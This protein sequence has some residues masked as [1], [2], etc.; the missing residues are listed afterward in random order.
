M[1]IYQWLNWGLGVSDH[2]A[3]DSRPS[4]SGGLRVWRVSF[5]EVVGV[6]MENDASAHH[7]NR[8]SQRSHRVR[9]VDVNVSG[10]ISLDVSE[11]ANM[12]VSVSW[13]SV[14]LSRWIIVPSGVQTA[15]SNISLLMNVE[16]M[17]SS[18]HRSGDRS[19]DS[20]LLPSL[21]KVQRT[22]ELITDASGHSIIQVASSVHI[23]SRR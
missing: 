4:V 18:R 17:Q 2:T 23:L 14:V 5:A 20:K 3:P 6:L 15:V 7:R 9:D 1:S 19:I 13:S 22:H 12:S 21:Y 11:I 10:S 16:A 8:P